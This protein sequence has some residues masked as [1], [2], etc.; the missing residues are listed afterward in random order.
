LSLK[1]HICSNFLVFKKLGLS[2]FL[3]KQRYS[4]KN[5]LREK[6]IKIVLV[7]RQVGAVLL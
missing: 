4:A 5:I 7:T 1:V 2:K 3:E 6:D